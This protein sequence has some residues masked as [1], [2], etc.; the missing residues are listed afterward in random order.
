MLGGVRAG[1]THDLP[2]LSSG[3]I[4][5]SVMAVR[6]NVMRNREHK[7]HSKSSMPVRYRRLHD[8]DIIAITA[9]AG[10]LLALDVDACCFSSHA[11]RHATGTRSEYL[12]MRVHRQVPD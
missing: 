6:E 3:L 12:E 7:P 5:S 9:P 4:L 1:R 8:T 10:S 2:M 11:S